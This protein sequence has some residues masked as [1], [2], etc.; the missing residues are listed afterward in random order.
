[1]A[2]QKAS[3]IFTRSAIRRIYRYSGGIPRLINIA[4]DRSLLTA[5][6]FNRNKVSGE[7]AAAAIDELATRGEKK[8]LAGRG[9][10]KI[11]LAG[12][13]M[14]LF[15]AVVWIYRPEFSLLFHGKAQSVDKAPL[16][17]QDKKPGNLPLEMNP[18]LSQ[19]AVS[20]ETVLEAP[21]EAD[22]PAPDQQPEIVEPQQ[23]S[24]EHVLQSDSAN[25][26]RTK[27]MQTV[28]NKWD[29]DEQISKDLN[30]VEN[31]M[32]F[33]ILAAKQ[34]GLILEEIN[35]DLARIR[36]LNICAILEFKSPDTHLPVYLT[37]VEATNY[38]MTFF[39][40]Q[41][42]VRMVFD[43]DAIRQY[44][45]GRAYVFWKNFYNYQG[46]LPFNTQ[47]ESIVTLKLHLRDIGFENVEINGAYDASTR[48]AVEAIQTKHGIPVDGYVG[49]LTKI[50]LY[51]EKPSLPIPRLNKQ[52]E[53]I[54]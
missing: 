40:N 25:I 6:G 30:V 38:S 22:I 36:S 17:D 2:S 20:P 4:C 3:S 49:P 9:H 26:S 16:T 53:M 11:A 13:C 23:V 37:A 43:D 48:K 41:A 18:N 12:L 24:L 44:W 33:F 50:A 42:N 51:N 29:A 10:T 28:L 14:A 39:E 35:G 15:F 21:P 52:T 8:Y 34:Q 7:I 45:T 32:D 31:D 47:N 46:I 54:H 1:V 5:Y 27:A 19:A